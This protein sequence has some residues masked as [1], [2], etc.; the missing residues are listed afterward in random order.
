MNREIK[1][2]VWLGDKMGYEGDRIGT[3]N[4]YWNQGSIVLSGTIDEKSSVG[5]I[6]GF[7]RKR[8]PIMQF[9]GLKDKNGKEIYEGDMLQIIK[10]WVNVVVWDSEICGFALVKY[11][12]GVKKGITGLTEPDASRLEIIGDIHT[13]P[14]LLK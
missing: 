10:G 8:K 5:N 1:F 2:R 3:G 11:Y 12:K 6:K 13:T 14:E 4:K 9:T 7:K